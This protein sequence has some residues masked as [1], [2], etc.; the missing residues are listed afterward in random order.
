L[1]TK[2][3]LTPFDLVSTAIQRIE[4]LN[5]SI[6]AVTIKLFDR[7]LDAARAPGLETRLFAGVPTLLK[8]TTA[9]AG[10]PRYWALKVLQDAGWVED[11]DSYLVAR[12]RDAG[13]VSLGRTNL[14]ELA[15]GIS[16]EPRLWG[17]CRNPWD[18]ER[19][20]GGSSG[21]SAAAVASGMVPIA[22]GTDGGG[23]VR[24]PASICG[25]VGLKPTRGRI[26]IGPDFSDTEGFSVPSVLTR[27]VRDTAAAVDA[28]SG[29]APG[30][31]W[32]APPLAHSLTEA[33]NIKP[34]RLR[35]G[36]WYQTRSFGSDVHPDCVAACEDAGRLLE[37]LGHIVEPAYP[38]ALDASFSPAFMVVATSIIRWE[39]LHIGKII[40]RPVE[41]TD[42]DPVIWR[43]SLA[44][45]QVMGEQ[46]TQAIADLRDHG[47]RFA[48]WWSQGWDIL[49]T[50]TIAVPPYL[51]G[52]TSAPTPDSPWPDIQSWVPFSG[53]FNQTGLPAISLPLATNAAGLPIGIQLGANLGREDLLIS[54]AA[55]LER[56]RPWADRW[57]PHSAISTLG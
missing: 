30:D 1:V 49:L 46:Y 32:Y 20:V 38:E 6:N 51:L 22:H 17:P 12:L 11:H 26:P 39:L 54:V 21:G 16:T 29:H 2:G 31:P 34:G 18:L 43:A 45:S 35:I 57:P 56:A 40:G 4:D 10:E 25:I 48:S 42:V 47:R 50:P 53:I 24:I 36:M 28:V 9:A 5:P 3:E 27:S 33:L 41:E 37:S 15:G 44:G 55:Q 52:T 23:S 8:D 19:S 13:L 7:A 14:P